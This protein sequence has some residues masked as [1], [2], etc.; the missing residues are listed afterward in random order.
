MEWIAGQEESRHSIL[1]RR[2]HS[3]EA[4]KHKSF[5]MCEKGKQMCQIHQKP[6]EMWSL[7]LTSLATK[8]KRRTQE[9]YSSFIWYKALYWFLYTHSHTLCISIWPASSLTFNSLVFSKHTM[10][11]HALWTRNSSATW[12]PTTLSSV[13]HILLQ[14]AAQMVHVLQSLPLLFQAELVTPFSMPSHY[15]LHSSFRILMFTAILL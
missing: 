15:F 2:P 3:R 1:S 12:K 9:G 4:R 14:G 10:L 8:A 7:F 6:R 11:F 13:R 5:L